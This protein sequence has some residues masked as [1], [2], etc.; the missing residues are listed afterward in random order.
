MVAGAAGP[1][2][3][4]EDRHLGVRPAELHTH[5]ER[6]QAADEEEDNRRDQELDADDLVIF[7]EDV[8]AEEAQLVVPVRMTVAHLRSSLSPMLSAVEG[9][10]RFARNAN[11]AIT[12]PLSV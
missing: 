8:L 1:E 3:L 7:G 9:C 11:N 4:P 10:L 2:P 12:A 5:Q 6:Q